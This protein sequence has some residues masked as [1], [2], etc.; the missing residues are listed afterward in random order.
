MLRRSGGADLR[1]NA[2]RRL[3]DRKLVELRVEAADL[4]GAAVV[5]ALDLGPADRQRLTGRLHCAE[6]ADRLSGPQ[7][8]EVDLDVE[9]FLHA[10]DVCVAE[11]LVGVEE[12]AVALD[13]GGG[14]DDL[15]AVDSA[16]ATLDLVLG[17]ERE[18][19]RNDFQSP[20]RGDI[21][22]TLGSIRKT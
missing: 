15:V 2:E 11:L 1:E 3:A 6:L 16:A 5:A 4:F 14:M 10:A 22:G 17:M 20:H 8:I 18:L 21:F 19:L 9:D 12:R 13:A 7:Q